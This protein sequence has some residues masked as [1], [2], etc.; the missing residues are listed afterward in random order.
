MK[1][2]TNHIYI[3]YMLLFFSKCD[4]EFL[5]CLQKWRVRFLVKVVSNS[6]VWL[7]WVQFEWSIMFPSF[8][9][10][11]IQWRV[12]P[13]LCI[14]SLMDQGCSG[15]MLTATK[16]GASKLKRSIMNWQT[17]TWREDCCVSSVSW[18][19]QVWVRIRSITLLI[20]VEIE[21]FINEMTHKVNILRFW[22][23]MWRPTH[24]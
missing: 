15:D 5:H 6:F 22:V 14:K 4:L 19:L 18:K 3:Y 21:H 2:W 1:K 13:P 10:G 9:R 24:L 12:R 23:K 8:V 20:K 7:F 16:G 17:Y 11:A